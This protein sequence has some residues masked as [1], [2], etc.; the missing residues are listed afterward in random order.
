MKSSTMIRGLAALAMCALLP[1]AWA[2]QKNPVSRPFKMQAHSQM[3]V[4]LA[5]YSTVATAWGEAT[6]CG[7][8]VALGWGEFNPATGEPT[9]SG[10]IIAANKDEIF[11]D[12]LPM[13]HNMITGGTGRFEGATGEFSVV[14]IEQTGM[15]LDP[16]AGTMTL[17]FVWTA[18]GTI[19]Y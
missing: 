5:D 15:E 17:S 3:V 16:F 7:K 4:S 13:G 2:S 11:Y 1:L 19:C 9:G 12:T 8:F 6:H 14:S 10:N 18:S